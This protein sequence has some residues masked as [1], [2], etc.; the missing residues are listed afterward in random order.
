[1][2]RDI[3]RIYKGLVGWPGPIFALQYRVALTPFVFAKGSGRL[4]VLPS[5]WLTPFS[6]ARGFPFSDECTPSLR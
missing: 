4:A 2:L 6:T 3:A 5:R 1:M